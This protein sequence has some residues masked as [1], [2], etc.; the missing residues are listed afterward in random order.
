VTA[1]VGNGDGTEGAV[2]GR[3]V[4]TYMHGPVLARNPALAD[5]LLSWALGDGAL[6]ALDDWAS[7]GLREERLAT[8][9]GRRRWRRRA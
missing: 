2:R 7:E 9:G 5:V 8:V 6:E 4:G 3:V 1:G